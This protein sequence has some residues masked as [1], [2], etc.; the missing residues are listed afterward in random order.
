MSLLEQD[1]LSASELIENAER[2]TGFCDWGDDDFRTALEVLVQSAEDEAQMTSLG[3]ER[4]RTWLALLLEQ[5]LKL[6]E[7]RKRYPGITEQSIVRPVFIMGLPRA[8]TTFL[9][10]LISLHPDTL[11][12][13]WWE[14]FVPSPPPNDPDIDHRPQIA[15]MDEFMR[16]QGW[17]DADVMRSHK[18]H[19]EEPEEDMFATFYSLIAMYFSGYLDV[20]SYLQYIA[21]RGPADSFAWHRRVLQAIQYG[22]SGKRFMLKAPGHT[23]HVPQLLENYPDAVLIQNHRD[24]SRVM[25]SVFSNMSA[26]RS[27]ISDRAQLIGRDEALAF[28]EMYAQGLV[29]AA[30]QRDKLKGGN[31]FMDVHYLDL[32][33]DPLACVK[34]ACRHADLEFTDRLEEQVLDWTK[35][36]RQDKYGKHK[37]A[38]ADYGLTQADVHSVFADYLE[39]FRIEREEEV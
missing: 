29:S 12:T 6:M 19:P 33:R 17:Y 8:G 10:R 23:L 7:D 34:A 1:S 38:L 24:P 30:E 35:A 39:R 11:T 25:A 21:G 26:T 2:V 20:P 16:F 32:V 9:H 4:V 36:N 31:L 14:L 37:Y 15:L 22:T 28:M 18:H 5:R 27:K 13:R 3:R